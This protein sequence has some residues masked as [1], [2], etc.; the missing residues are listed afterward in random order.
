MDFRGVI[1]CDGYAGYRSFVKS[2]GAGQIQLAA[3]YAHAR[4]KFYEA[5]DHAPRIVGWLLRQIGLLYVIEKRLREERAGPRLRE[6]IR[7]SQSRII[8]ERLHRALV[9]LNIKKR[10]LPQ[11][12]L[13]KAID[14]T[15]GQWTGLSVFLE[16]GSVEIDNNL[17]ENA[18][19]PTAIGKKNWLFI[20]DADAGQRG[21]ILYTLI[22]NCHRRGIDPYAYLRDVLTKLPTMTNRQIKNVTPEAY[23]SSIQDRKLHRV[24]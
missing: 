5:Q 8:H 23:A 15:L 1:Q 22:E 3:C 9:R 18:I 11:S 24:S 21:A 4:R 13:G 14:Y 20:G 2:L 6:A 17:V 12:A 7:A 19:R 10:D 16:N